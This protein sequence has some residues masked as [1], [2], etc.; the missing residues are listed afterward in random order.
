[1]LR[2]LRFTT[3]ISCLLVVGTTNA[4]AKNIPDWIISD[5]SPSNGLNQKTTKVHRRMLLSG[6]KHAANT[7][8]NEVL[9]Q[10]SIKIGFVLKKGT[11]YITK[12]SQTFNKGLSYALAVYKG[13]SWSSNVDYEHVV[14]CN[15][16][17]FTLDKPR[18]V[19]FTLKRQSDRALM[20]LARF[21]C[22][23]E[24]LFYG[25]N[26]VRPNTAPAALLRVSD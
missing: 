15:S 19:A 16:H 24:V 22:T 1:M 6:T 7:S 21:F 20:S 3:F 2:I 12:R 8:N 4:N 26:G 14:T 13:R 17:C 9:A 18:L 10:V 25:L 11:Y 5:L 23:D